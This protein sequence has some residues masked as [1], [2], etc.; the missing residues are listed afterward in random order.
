MNTARVVQQQDSVVP[1]RRWRCE[2]DP[3]APSPKTL[4][5]QPVLPSVVRSP[6]VEHHYLHNMPAAAWRCFGVFSGGS[7]SGAVVFTAGTR[8]GHRA[9]VGA[10]PQQVATLARLW[11]ADELPKN[12]E[13]RVIG[14]V[15]R[16][17]RRDSPWKALLSY[18]D[19]AAG[20]VGTIYQAT[21][22]IYL[23]QTAPA[24]YVDLGDGKALHP[25]TVYDRL[26]SNAVGHLRRTG[27]PARRAVVSGKH[28]YVYVLD[29]GWRW[30]LRDRPQPYPRPAVS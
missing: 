4:I 3:R 1:P 29:L 11:L 2:S 28:R 7:L 12:A 16:L 15:L 10:R 26:G 9:I 13:S 20:H 18:A 23:G 24:S 8:Q 21:G 14:V 25:R 17:L 30:R 22:W 6:I 5:V 19:P 27:I